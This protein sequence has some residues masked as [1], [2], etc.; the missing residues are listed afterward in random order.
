M[1]NVFQYNMDLNMMA[2]LNAKERT[3]EELVDLGWVFLLGFP[4]VACSLTGVGLRT[5]ENKQDSGS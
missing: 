3:L 4:V 1:G 2:L 5:A